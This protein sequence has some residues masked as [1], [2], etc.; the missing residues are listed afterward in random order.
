MNEKALE[1]HRFEEK[2]LEIPSFMSKKKAEVKA[3]EKGHPVLLVTL[4]ML[5]CI[6]VILMGMQVGMSAEE[7]LLYGGLGVLL[8]TIRVG[9]LR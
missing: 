1:V 8:M 3:E 4:G 6:G 5:A 9:M 2:P 7:Y